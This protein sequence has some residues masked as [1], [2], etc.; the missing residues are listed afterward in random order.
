M[1]T[2]RIIGDLHEAEAIADKWREL[3]SRA[4]HDEP[5]STPSWLL[6]WWKQFGDQ[7][8]RKLRLVLVEEDGK[9]LAIAP[10]S[11]RLVMFRRAIPSRRLELL[12]TG[13]NEQDE[14]CSD[15]VGVIVEKGREADVATALA[16]ALLKD[17]ALGP[18][19]ELLMP[20]MS[21]EDAFVEPLR[22]ALESEG[23]KVE[24]T[25][26]GSCPHIPLPK[27]WDDYV[28]ALD[29]SRRYVVTRS[30]RELEKWAGKDGYALVRASNE[31]ELR[32][33]RRI[34]HSLHGER[35]EGQGET[36]VFASE[37]F[38]RFHDEMMPKLLAGKDGALDLLWLTV[39]GEP[40]AAV[41]NIIYGKKV[42]FYQSGRKLDVPKSVKIGIAMH[43]LAIKRSIDAGHREYDF[44]NGASQYKRQLALSARPLVSL[45]A[46]APSLRARAVDA[47]L[48]LAERAIVRVRE[49]KQNKEK[50][51]PAATA[52]NDSPG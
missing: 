41:Y 52:A 7:G 50:R 33:G 27:A 35:W 29:S 24:V 38:T 26:S 19:D 13:E 28:K 8:G 37:R 11:A 6:A 4:S 47:A 20:A 39:K 32:E 15:Y 34:L 1:I 16:R 45:R 18:W 17:A 43:A 23:A 46:V 44:L 25:P 42:Y 31:D 22:R 30:L 36:G 10:L 12:A 14:I 2:T 3:L 49:Y 48:T 5:V 40:V 21:G 51:A 9:L